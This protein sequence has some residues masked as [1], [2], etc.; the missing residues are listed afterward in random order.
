MYKL[1][2]VDEVNWHASYECG[3]SDGSEPSS[4]NLQLFLEYGS[5][6]MRNMGWYWRP[7]LMGFRDARGDRNPPN[8]GERSRR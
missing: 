8:T 5:A 4:Y 3:Y 7:Y 2:R 6:H 1:V